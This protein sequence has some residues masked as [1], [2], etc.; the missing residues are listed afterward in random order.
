MSFE[1][2]IRCL[3]KN[4][5]TAPYLAASVLKSS[6]LSLFANRSDY[7]P[8]LT[9]RH[10]PT[11]WSILVC[12]CGPLTILF[13]SI[14]SWLPGK[15]LMLQVE[16]DYLTSCNVWRSSIG[17]IGA[18]TITWLIVWLCVCIVCRRHLK[19]IKAKEPSC[20]HYIIIYF[21][22]S[23]LYIVLCIMYIYIYIFL[24]VHIYIYIYTMYLPAMSQHLPTS[25]SMVWSIGSSIPDRPRYP[26]EYRLVLDWFDQ[27]CLG[28]MFFR[29]AW[30]LVPCFKHSRGHLV[31]LLPVKGSLEAGN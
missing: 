4:C 18:S 30:D 27:Q 21:N 2:S 26:S 11:H 22:A 3:A 15:S 9:A 6:C 17:S 1:Q 16:A 28:K 5:K 25:P 14:L 24:F 12:C 10:C 23:V 19:N 31:T 20:T 29:D 13:Y 8:Y 7:C